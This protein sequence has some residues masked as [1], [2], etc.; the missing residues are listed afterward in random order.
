MLSLNALLAID[1]GNYNVKTS[2][3]VIFNSKFTTVTPADTK[4]EFCLEYNG[5]KY[6]IDRG[7]FDKEFNKADKDYIPLLL[8][9][10]YKSVK[11][12]EIELLLGT[13]LSQVKQKDKIINNLLGETFNFKVNGI[14]QSITFRRVGVLPEGY[15]SFYV[16]NKFQRNTRVIIIDIGGRTINVVS[17]I[18]GKLEKSDTIPFGIMDFYETIKE[19]ENDKG[20]KLTVEEIE[21]LIEDNRIDDVNFEKEEFIKSILNEI[22]MNFE[23]KLYDI[24]FTGGGTVVLS[25]IIRAKIRRANIMEN[26][27]FS[28][29]NGN[30]NIAKAKWG[31]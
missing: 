5:V 28:N 27:I 14:S 18:K 9:A 24:Y 6:Y 23:T 19:R 2:T 7:K 31:E 21:N 4:E 10:C 13:P 3:G 16:L 26:P 1:L 22:K 12:R 8:A 29:V 15:S 30:Y 25:D 17:F 20:F 11:A